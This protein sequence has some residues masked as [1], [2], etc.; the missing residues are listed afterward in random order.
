MHLK[1]VS[2]EY[3][4]KAKANGKAFCIEL[5]CRRENRRLM[6]HFR[7]DIFMRDWARAI[8]SSIA[9][10][11]MDAPPGVATMDKDDDGDETDEAT[12]VGSSVEKV[13]IRGYVFKRSS[14]V[15][16]RNWRERYF[17]VTSQYWEAEQSKNEKEN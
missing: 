15:F 17:I 10:C 9:F 11:S 6:L 13:Y 1:D 12:Q 3:A 4:D 14:D 16:F 5:V 8:E 7:D 2:I